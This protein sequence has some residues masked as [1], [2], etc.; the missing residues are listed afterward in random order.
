MNTP[1]NNAI[2]CCAAAGMVL[3][4]AVA[5][6]AAAGQSTAAA[7]I[8]AADIAHHIQ[9]LASDKFG[10][11]AP[12]SP[13]EK[14]TIDYIRAHFK[15]Y[16]LKPPVN[17]GYFQTVPLVKVTTD[18]HT[19][20]TVAGGNK[21]L[22]FDYANDMIVWTT[23]EAKHID[24][25]NSPLVFVGYGIVAPEYHWND[26]AGVDV[27]G[28]TVV[29]LV[30]DPGYATHNPKLFTGRAMTYYGRWTYKYEEAARQGAAGALIIHETGPAGYPWKV[31]SGSWSG[32]QFMLP[33]PKN[34][35]RPA[36]EGWLTHQSAEQVFAAAGLDLDKL[37][38]A[39]AR[40]DFKA[41]PLHLTASVAF[42]N[43]IAHVHS[44]NVIGMIPG[45]EHPD[46]AVIY[47]AHWDH[48]GTHPNMPG[49]N[50]YNG[51]RDDA[52]GVA[53]LLELAQAYS[54]LKQPPARSVLFLATTSEEQGL[55]GAKWYTQHPVAPL[56]T[57][58]ADIN[59]DIMNVWG[60]THD[61]TVI[62]YGSSQLEDWLRRAAK[63]RGRALRPDPEPEKGF[64]FRADHFAFA[65]KGVPALFTEAGVDYLHHPK[66]WGLKK[67]HE[68]TREHY[69]KPS[70]EYNPKW[71]LSGEA[72][73][74]KLLF[75]VG[76]RLAN[77]DAWPDWYTGNQFKALRDQ[78]RGQRQGDSK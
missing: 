21:P 20:L 15:Q 32:P 58:V 17:D 19:T 22:H 70:D 57:T 37:Q 25:K 3:G 76:E 39:A 23:R 30:N 35:Y 13:G 4:L 18:P 12:A 42:D 62:G 8:S 65:K 31:V 72:A 2:R 10:G 43:R 5:G 16:G 7:S 78:T 77:S 49:D 54:K 26:Y 47:S 28:K 60:K 74:L 55:L 71:N 73:D 24:L 50:I 53:G 33:P 67:E 46:D 27:K 11:R 40:R 56:A 59:M 63:R 69:H 64:Y 66:G 41:R 9:V 38:A 29:I 14:L 45:R 52:S 51:A 34:S 6:T 48:L 44:H 75:T 1:Q 61:I 36:V 68:Y